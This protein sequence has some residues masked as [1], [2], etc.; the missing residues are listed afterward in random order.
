MSAWLANMESAR[1]VIATT[2]TPKRRSAGKMA[3]S[4]SL[5]PLLLMASTMSLAST[6]PKSPWLASAGCTNIAGVPVLANVAAI[7]RPT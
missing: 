6:M 4:S 2:L 5:S 7:L 3:A 1:P